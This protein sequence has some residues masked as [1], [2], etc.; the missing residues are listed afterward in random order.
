MPPNNIKRNN[1]ASRANRVARMLRTNENTRKKLTR[2]LGSRSLVPRVPKSVTFSN[3]NPSF[4][5]NVENL[6]ETNVPF[7]MNLI[8][9]RQSILPTRPKKENPYLTPEESKLLANISANATTHEDM[10]NIVYN[11]NIPRNTKKKLLQKIEFMYY[12]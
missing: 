4:G 6:D 7:I 5:A 11:S 9:S 1:R 3:R 12:S 10:V 2:Q 8:K